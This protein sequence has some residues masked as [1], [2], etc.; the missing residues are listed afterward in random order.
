LSPER[1][2]LQVSGVVVRVHASRG[3]CRRG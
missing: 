2:D 3:I 1:V